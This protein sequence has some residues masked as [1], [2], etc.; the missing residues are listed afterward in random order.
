MKTPPQLSSV[1]AGVSWII[2]GTRPHW[3]RPPCGLVAGTHW[4]PPK[5]ESLTELHQGLRVTVL[6][7]VLLRATWSLAGQA[8]PEGRPLPRGLGPQAAPECAFVCAQGRG[9][10]GGLWT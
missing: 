10:V 8:A 1:L 3:D 6:P 4:V 5:S 9:G 2:S 7:R